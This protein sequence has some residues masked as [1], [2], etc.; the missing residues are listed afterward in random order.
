MNPQPD[1]VSGMIYWRRKA[2]DRRSARYAVLADWLDDL[3][4]ESDFET[5]LAQEARKC[6]DTFTRRFSDDP[7][8]WGE[9]ILL[10]SCWLSSWRVT[11]RIIKQHM[12][13]LRKTFTQDEA[14][15]RTPFPP[16]LLAQIKAARRER[17]ENKTR[18]YQREARGEVIRR[19][20]LRRKQ[21]P[22]AHVL[23]KMTPQERHLDR[24]SRSSVS[25]VGYVGMVKR[26]LGWKLRNPEAWK[27]EHGQEED[28]P[29][30][31]AIEEEIRRKNRKRQ[32]DANKELEE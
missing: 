4:R 25:E 15:R 19:T 9:F 30:L 27:A 8:E 17:V 6:G 3:R 28:W 7:Q 16:E 21:G 11:E 29:T 20:I 18:E 13:D 2:R 31:D 24:V 10:V 1:H 26:K 12:Y 14:R 22:P 23:A 5:R 32:A